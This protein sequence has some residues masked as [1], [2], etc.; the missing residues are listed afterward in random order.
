MILKQ[1]F[2][3]VVASGHGQRVEVF[4][5]LF[6]LSRGLAVSFLIAGILGEPRRITKQACG[7]PWHLGWRFLEHG[8]SG[9]LTRASFFSSSYYSSYDL[10][11]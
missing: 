3:A 1:M 7:A 10:P 8:S 5:G 4:N 9:T 11:R 2:L 6:N